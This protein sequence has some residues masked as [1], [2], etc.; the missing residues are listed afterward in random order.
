MKKIDTFIGKIVKVGVN[1][2][3]TA[4]VVGVHEPKRPEKLK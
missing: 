4:S 3:S 1:V 2:A